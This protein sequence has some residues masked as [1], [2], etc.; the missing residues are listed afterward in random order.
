MFSGV[1]MELAVIKCINPLRWRRNGS[2]GY[3]MGSFKGKTPLPFTFFLTFGKGLAEAN[4]DET[5][6]WC[7]TQSIVCRIQPHHVLH[8][9]LYHLEAGV[10]ADPAQQQQQRR[11]ALLSRR[12][13]SHHELGI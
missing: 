4:E 5:P 8:I 10:G 12:R 9:E 1:L 3:N 2:L 13:F 11:A 6:P 7:R